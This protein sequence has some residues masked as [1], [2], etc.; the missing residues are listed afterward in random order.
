MIK[1]YQNKLFKKKHGLSWVCMSIL[2]HTDD[3]FSRFPGWQASGKNS[4]GGGSADPY[5]QYRTPL[6]S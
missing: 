5:T 4:P 2:T 1:I 3:I 6:A